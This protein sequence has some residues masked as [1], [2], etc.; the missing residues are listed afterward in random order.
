VRY[1]IF[2]ITLHAPIAIVCGTNFDA[3][4]HRSCSLLV[5]QEWHQSFLTRY[6][7]H[8]IRWI[9]VKDIVTLYPDDDETK[10]TGGH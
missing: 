4:T 3:M 9:H 8:D 6:S 5:Y 1:Q 7:H 2:Y 10:D